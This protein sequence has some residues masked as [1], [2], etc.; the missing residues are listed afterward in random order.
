MNWSALSAIG[1]M[2]AAFVGIA[3]IWLNLLEKNRRLSVEF[4]ITP[5]F[6]LVI[7]NNSLKTV[8]ISKVYFSQKDHIFYFQY[9]AESG[10]LEIPPKTINNIK[11]DKS[12]VYQSYFDHKIDALC[13]PNEIIV[14]HVFDSFGRGYKIKTCFGI[15]GFR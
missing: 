8:A 5:Y 10:T 9:L 6:R 15:A 1:T 4:E 12:A 7:C 13:N 2:L 3:G 14:I 11:I